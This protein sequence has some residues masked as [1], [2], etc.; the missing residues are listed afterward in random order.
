MKTIFGSLCASVVVLLTSCT[1]LEG[2]KEFTEGGEITYTSTAANLTAYPGNERVMLTYGLAK[3]PNINRSVITWNANKD[4]LVLAYDRY[5][6]EWIVD[7]TLRYIIDDLP[8]GSYS[9]EIQN[10]DRLGNKSVPASVSTRSYGERYRAELYDRSLL[11]VEAINFGGDL[12][13]AWG[14][15][16]MNSVG[17]E[18]KYTARDGSIV[19]R[20]IENAETEPVLES[21]EVSEPI[22]YRTLYKPVENCMDT[23]ATDFASYKFEQLEMLMPSS[24]FSDFRCD[25]DSPVISGNMRNLWDGLRSVTVAGDKWAEE[26]N[27]QDFNTGGTDDNMQ[28]PGVFTINLGVKAKLSRIRISF[29]WPWYNACPKV[30]EIYAY[31]GEGAPD[32]SGDWSQWTKI[33]T[34]DNTGTESDQHYAEGDNVYFKDKATAPEVQYIRIK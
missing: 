19:N 6:S 9:F 10:F 17:V 5:N 7:D 12:K 20:F 11:S 2:Y 16:T 14:D 23:F 8:E 22:F 21:C 32:K 18:V 28:L 27:W 33:Q 1:D 26:V 29:Y 24:T 4:S 15:S 34:I 30:Y 31:T 3:N 13:M 25:N